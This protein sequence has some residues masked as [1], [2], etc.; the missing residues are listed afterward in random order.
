VG[1]IMRIGSVSALVLAAFALAACE[2]SPTTGSSAS[3][4]TLDLCGLSCPDPADGS[5]SGG[6]G[7]GGSTDGG[8]TTN[9]TPATADTTIALE[10]SVYQ[11]PS[12][13]TSLS[14][15]TAGTSPTTTT[16]QILGPTKPTALTI[17]VDTNTSTN[18]NWPTPVQMTEYVPGS[19]AVDPTG[20]NN[21]G[22]DCL[23]NCGYREYRALSATRDEELQ[24]WAWN[25]SYATQY[26]NASG[27]GEATQ[28][29]WSF[30][31]NRTAVTG[32]PVAGSATYN[33]RFVAT[34]KSSNWI[35]PSGANIDPNGLWRVQGASSVTADFGALTVD[36]TLTPETWESFQQGVSGWYTWNV[37]TAGTVAEP[38]YEI[39]NAQVAL[40][41]TI[42]GNTYTGTA[43]LDGTFVSGDNPMHG[44]FFGA[45]ASETTGIFNVYGV[46]PDP[47][48]GSAGINDDRRGFLTINGA[49][50]G[51]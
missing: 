30:G 4:A 13:G 12:S 42:T 6:S 18:G 20:N 22:T 1:K 21:G 11:R 32:M 50:N 9:L 44:G 19:T 26:R 23:P 45:G 46:D 14:L 29:A 16:A 33:G 40:E 25:E 31:G 41:G 5:G 24:V 3:N 51:N 38:D 28:Q 37:G 10:S 17:R 43:A 27:G 15:L 48:G 35:K 36:G 49:F 34:A 8:N 47:I 2:G 7:G 39:Y